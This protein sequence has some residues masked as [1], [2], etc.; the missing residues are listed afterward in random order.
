MTI[1]QIVDIPA[2]RKIIVELPPTIP[3]GAARLKLSVFHDKRAA[4]KPVKMSRQMRKLLT[5]YG[6]LRDDPVFEGDPVE[7]QRKM[8]VEWD[9]P[10]DP[11]V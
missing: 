11:N 7:I 1:E 6:C 8:R 9:R 5:L 3:T 2:D 4:E 10:R